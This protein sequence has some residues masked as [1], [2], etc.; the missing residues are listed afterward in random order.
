MLLLVLYSISLTITFA[1]DVSNS[2]ESDV[3]LPD[4]FG[5][6]FGVSTDQQKNV[7]VHCTVYIYNNIIYNNIMYICICTCTCTCT[8][9]CNMYNMYMF[10]VYMYMYICICIYVY[11][12]VICICICICICIIYTTVNSQKNTLTIVHGI[13]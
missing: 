6:K 7:S 5:T 3:F 9:I 4:G 1:I 11:V 13:W 12:Y 10:I 2:L 8:C